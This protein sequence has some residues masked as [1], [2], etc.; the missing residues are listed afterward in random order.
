MTLQ[1]TT[2]ISITIKMESLS[3]FESNYMANTTLGLLKFH[4]IQFSYREGLELVPVLKTAMNW[5]FTIILISLSKNAVI[6][7]NE[8][9]IQSKDKLFEKNIFSPCYQNWKFHMLFV[10]MVFIRYHTQKDTRLMGFF[11]VNHKQVSDQTREFILS[12]ISF[13]SL[14][15]CIVT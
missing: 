12:S 10:L 9:T 14:T 8:V 11:M 15:Q 3:H 1:F 6:L 2:Y 5:I 7:C 13:I 4:Y